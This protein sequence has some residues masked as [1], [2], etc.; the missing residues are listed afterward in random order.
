MVDDVDLFWLISKYST[1]QKLIIMFCYW[2]FFPSLIRHEVFFFFFLLS[3]CTCVYGGRKGPKLWSVAKKIPFQHRDPN[4]PISSSRSQ[5]YF[6]YNS[7]PPN[8]D[9][10]VPVLGFL[11]KRL[12]ICTKGDEFKVWIISYIGVPDAEDELHTRIRSRR[13]VSYCTLVSLIG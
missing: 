8:T 9:S 2:K 1:S 13:I 6:K 11:G 10:K 4:D 12:N 5:V 3:S 7:L